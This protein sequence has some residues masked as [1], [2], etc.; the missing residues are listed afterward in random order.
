MARDGGDDADAGSSCAR[1]LRAARRGL[2]GVLYLM[3]K[4]KAAVCGR[5]ARTC[6]VCVCTRVDVCAR[7]VGCS[8]TPA[9]QSR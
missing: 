5:G 2:F 9:F 3:N 4:R 6:S 8:R 7:R 1:S